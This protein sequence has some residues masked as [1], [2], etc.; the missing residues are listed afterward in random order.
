MAEK[1]G[2]RITHKIGPAGWVAGGD[3]NILLFKTRQE[4]EKALR[5]MKSDPH[6]LWKCEAQAMEFTGF[7]KQ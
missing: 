6:Y 5:Q 4:A 2:I 7:R 3:C 1:Y